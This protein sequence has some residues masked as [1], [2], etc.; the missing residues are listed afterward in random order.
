MIVVFFDPGQDLFFFLFCPKMKPRPLSSGPWGLPIA[1]KAAVEPLPY[2]RPVDKPFSKPTVIASA[3]VSS[4]LTQCLAITFLLGITSIIIGLGL[5]A[6]CINSDRFSKHTSTIMQMYE[7][8]V[9]MGAFLS[10]LF[11][12]RRHIVNHV[13]NL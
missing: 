10:Y 4:I 5:F 2:F 6:W 8:C 9:L 12:S 11:V 3:T 13:K 1:E 7:I